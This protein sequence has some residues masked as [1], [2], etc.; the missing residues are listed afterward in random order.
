MANNNKT[1]ASSSPLSPI[2]RFEQYHRRE[3]RE[4]ERERGGGGESNKQNPAFILMK[5]GSFALASPPLPIKALL[6]LLSHFALCLWDYVVWVADIPSSLSLQANLPPLLDDCLHMEQRT[7][8][9]AALPP[10]NLREASRENAGLRVL[11]GLCSRN[12]TNRR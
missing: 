6:P 7:V 2:D 1:A 8:V 10:I 5:R 11:C 12:L 9:A 4:R 3:W